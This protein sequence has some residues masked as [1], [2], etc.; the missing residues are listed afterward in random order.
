MRDDSW[1]FLM[2]GPSQ[3]EQAELAL[4][5][6]RF[7]SH[8]IF[9]EA[10]IGRGVRYLAHSALPGARPHTIITDN[11]T[12]LRGVLEQAAPP[13]LPPLILVGSRQAECRKWLGAA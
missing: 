13:G 11:L 4:L 3:A 2:P 1:A 8:H 6:E 5:R 12:E 10:T 7:R 9:R